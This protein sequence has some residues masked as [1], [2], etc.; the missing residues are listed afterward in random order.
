MLVSP[1]A[2]ILSNMMYAAS[3]KYLGTPEEMLMS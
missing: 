2:F 1:L 3:R